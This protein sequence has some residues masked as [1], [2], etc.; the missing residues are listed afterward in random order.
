MFQGAAMI[1]LIAF[2]VFIA[3]IFKLLSVNKKLGND[4]ENEE[5]QKKKEVIIKDLK[6]SG[7]AFAVGLVACVIL[8]FIINKAFLN[9]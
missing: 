2:V 5:L 6:Q 3:S 9:S 7:I 8:F 1:T 4:P